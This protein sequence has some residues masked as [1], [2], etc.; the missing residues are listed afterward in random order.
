MPCFLKDPK[1]RFDL[2]LV[3]QVCDAQ[4]KRQLV[5]LQSFN[6]DFENVGFVERAHVLIKLVQI[7][8]RE[9]HL[10]APAAAGCFGRCRFH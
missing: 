10:F 2:L 9:A 3:V 6:A 8:T 5:F 4:N 7:L 1:T